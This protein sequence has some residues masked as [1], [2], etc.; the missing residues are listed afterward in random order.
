MKVIGEVVLSENTRQ[1]V[2]NAVRTT[3]RNAFWT[4]GFVNIY[5]FQVTPA[6]KTENKLTF[7]CKSLL[8]EGGFVLSTAEGN[9][10]PKTSKSGLELV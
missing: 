4:S 2:P 1:L 9:F 10:A 7:V 8:C 3:D 6:T 5:P